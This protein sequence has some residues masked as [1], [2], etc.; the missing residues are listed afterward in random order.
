MNLLY[1]LCLLCICIYD[2]SLLLCY[3]EMPS[4]KLSLA[5]IFRTQ[6][7]HRKIL[8]MTI[9]R[10]AS[11]WFPTQSY[12]F[13]KPKLR[14]DCTC[15]V[16]FQIPTTMAAKLCVQH[17]T[18]SLDQSSKFNIPLVNQFRRAKNHLTRFLRPTM[19]LFATNFLYRLLPWQLSLNTWQKQ[20]KAF[21][22]FVG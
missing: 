1:L 16:A 4:S 12:F 19:L 22:N 9:T 21:A 15:S 17:C 18:A 2:Q 8:H 7:K 14:L 13:L 20:L 3:L 5:K 10:M 11:I 6:T